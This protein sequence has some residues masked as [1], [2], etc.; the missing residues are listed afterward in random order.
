MSH[1]LGYLKGLIVLSMGLGA[2]WSYWIYQHKTLWILLLGIFI[3]YHGIN[4]LYQGLKQRF[5]II[6][7]QQHCAQQNFQYYI[8]NNPQHIQGD[9]MSCNQCNSQSIRLHIDHR[10]AEKQLLS[11]VQPGIYH[12]HQCKQCAAVLFYS[13]FQG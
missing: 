5:D 13:P 10:A 8:Q 2:V 6:H 11:R 9:V 4:I 7:H 12:R 3:A 1:I